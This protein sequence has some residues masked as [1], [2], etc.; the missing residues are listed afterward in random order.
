MKRIA[1]ITG[2]TGQDGSYLAEY[3]L[4]LGYVVYGSVRRSST[5]ETGCPHRLAKIISHPDL[6]L[7]RGIDLLNSGSIEGFISQIKSEITSLIHLGNYVE[8]YNLAAMSHVGDSFS[9]ASLTHR[10]NAEAVIVLL[11][12]LRRHFGGK[13]FRFYQASTSELFGN[14]FTETTTRLS[15]KSRF[16]PTSPYAV[17]KLAAFLTVRNYREAYNIHAVNGILFN[18]ESPRR[19][20]DFVTRKITLGLVEYVLGK[21]GAVELGNLNSKRDWGDAR[22][23][24]KV[25]HKM[26]D[27]NPAKAND[28]VVATGTSYSIKEFCNLALAKVGLEVEWRGTGVNEYAA[29]GNEVVIRVNPKFYRPSEVHHLVGDASKLYD[30]FGWKYT[31][32]LTSLVSDMVDSDFALVKTGVSL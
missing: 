5:P 20:V 13:S 23:Y 31:G 17:A 29:V 8:V 1:I 21:G 26:L 25:M 10:I 4:G 15:E 32:N 30:V 16:N 28:Y 19:G 11:D 27:C 24:V 3:L 14:T 9:M 22:E 6:R 7:I 2:I 18:H 12:T